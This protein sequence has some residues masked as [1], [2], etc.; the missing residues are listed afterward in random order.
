MKSMK[1]L[2]PLFILIPFITSSQSLLTEDMLWSTAIGPGGNC[3]N[4]FCWSYY[5]KIEG[6]TSINEIQYKKVK[7]SNDSFMDKW[8]NKGFIR[9]EK[10]QYI[11][12]KINSETECLLYDF[13][14]SVGDTL[15][16]NCSC[17][18]NSLF[19]VDSIKY[20]PVLGEERKHI[21]LTYLIN[22]SIKGPTEYWIEGIG[23]ITGILNGG[24]HGNCM[25]GGGEMLLCC[26]KNKVEIFHAT[27]YDNCFLGQKIVNSALVSHVNDRILKTGP[28]PA[29]DRIIISNPGNIKIRKIEIIDLSGRVVQNWAGLGLRENVLQLKN[30]LPGIYLVK[31]ETDFG[32]KTEKLVIQ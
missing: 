13:G 5:T 2:L 16:L 4:F 27:D 8:T 32:V 21:Y 26:L 23:S 31:M 14:C 30:I 24:G 25:T 10:Q 17:L 18:D 22:D 28:N 3:G 9:E 12:R 7:T 20:L 19:K 11:F 29:T 6:D 1:Y 15:N